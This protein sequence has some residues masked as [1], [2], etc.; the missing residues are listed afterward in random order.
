L[1]NKKDK[2]LPTALLVDDQQ[3]NLF[4]LQQMFESL[5]VAT[6]ISMSGNKAIEML[7]QRI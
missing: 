4:A 1:P 7:S 3:F 6:D 2:G 5:G